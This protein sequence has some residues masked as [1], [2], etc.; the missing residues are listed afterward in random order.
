M[1]DE[2]KWS[3]YFGQ[4]KNEPGP[5]GQGGGDHFGNFVE[6]VKTRKR[7]TLKGEVLEGH[8]SSA[9]CHLGNI[10]YRLG[11]GLKFD[12]KTETFVGD[13]DADALLTARVP[14]PLLHARKGLIMEGC[15]RR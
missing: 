1:L 6:A 7:E 3:T 2:G 5:K 4:G 8:L 9:L 13:K 14:L 10:A 12:P 15:P 11:R